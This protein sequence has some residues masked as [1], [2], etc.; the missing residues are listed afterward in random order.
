MYT[1]LFSLGLAVN[2]GGVFRSAISCANGLPYMCGTRHPVLHGSLRRAH[3]NLVIL[4]C[5]FLTHTS[6]IPVVNIQKRG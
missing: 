3:A 5:L 6:P 4:H 1:E 2:Y